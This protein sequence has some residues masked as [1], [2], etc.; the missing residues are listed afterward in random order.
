MIGLTQRLSDVNTQFCERTKYFM[1]GSLSGANDLRKVKSMF[2]KDV[3][4][5]LIHEIQALRRGEFILV[6]TYNTENSLKIY[7]P[8]FEQSGVPFEWNI[9][10]NGHIRVERVFL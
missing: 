1:I 6:D 3:G 10:N 9:G 8:K 7:F 5:R 4:G 2:E